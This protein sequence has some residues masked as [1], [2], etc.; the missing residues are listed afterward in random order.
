MPSVIRVNLEWKKMIGLRM[1]GGLMVGA[2]LTAWN[3]AH[4]DAVTE[5]NAIAVSCV[6]GSLSPPN[7]GGP[8]GL[9]DIALVQAAV[10]DAVQAI[11]GRFEPYEYDNRK[12]RGIG[13]P[14]AAAAAASHG[15]LKGLY[16]SNNPCL[17]AV[18]DPAGT[19]AGDPGLKAGTEA[20]I[21][22]LPHTRPTFG[23]PTDPFI[24]KQDAGQW[25]PHIGRDAGVRHVPG[26]YGAAGDEIALAIPSRA[27]AAAHESAVCQG[28]LRGQ[29]ARRSDQQQADAGAGRHRTVLDGELLFAVERSFASHRR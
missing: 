11:Q 22:L 16:G 25:R 21:A 5:W 8:A 24:G 1:V 7:R 28:V 18:I 29:G 17:V 15:M 4:A 13:S 10:R 6:Q 23:L 3:T 26:P 12:L 19:Y 14:E 2:A 27:A 20:A 9:L